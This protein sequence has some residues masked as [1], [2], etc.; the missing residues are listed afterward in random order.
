MVIDVS[1]TGADDDLV[2]GVP[3]WEALRYILGDSLGTASF[4]VIVG[5]DDI[6][7]LQ[8]K[9]CA[10]GRSQK[11]RKAYTDQL[12]KEANRPKDPP[13]LPCKLTKAGARRTFKDAVSADP[14]QPPAA[15]RRRRQE[16]SGDD[17]GQDEFFGYVEPGQTPP[18]TRRLLSVLSSLCRKTPTGAGLWTR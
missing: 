3:G 9:A 14:A 10:P 8:D 1:A 7:K 4:P 12:V 18:R 6:K 2:S 5:D 13:Y 11:D 16:V 17:Y 15:H